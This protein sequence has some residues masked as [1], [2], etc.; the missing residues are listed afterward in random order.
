MRQGSVYSRSQKNQAKISKKLRFFSCSKKH[1]PNG[2]CVVSKQIL[3]FS[4]KL[5]HSED[6]R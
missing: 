5:H 3:P 4:Q 2:A 1:A 6:H